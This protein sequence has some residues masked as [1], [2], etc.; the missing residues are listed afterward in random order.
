MSVDELLKAVDNLSEPDLES[1]VD[2]ALF[3]RARRRAPVATPEEST[4]LR[5]INRSIPTELTDLYELLADKRDN[6]TLTETEYAELLEIGDRL[7]VFGVKRL[8]ALV[9]LAE[10]RQIPLLQLMTDLG[11]QTPEIR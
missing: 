9:K 2:R 4:L 8:E 5:E 7:E 3:V 10:L 1:L 11:I 6:E